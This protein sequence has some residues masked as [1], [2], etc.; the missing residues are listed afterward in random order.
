M[1]INLL[2]I[3][4]DF[5]YKN[6]LY[7][8]SFNFR[9]RKKS[10]ETDSFSRSQKPLSEIDKKILEHFKNPNNGYGSRGQFCKE[11]NIPKYKYNYVIQEN[12]PYEEIEKIRQQKVRPLTELELKILEHFRNPNNGSR[13]VMQFCK[14][15]NVKPKKYYDIVEKNIPY[16][17]RE[18]IKRQKREIEKANKP[19][20]ELDKKILEHFKN[21]SNG[22]GS[23]VQFC[24]ENN[25]L[26][27]KYTMVIQANISKEEI[28]ILKQ[29][30]KSFGISITPV[31]VTSLKEAQNPKNG[32]TF[33]TNDTSDDE[34]E[35]IYISSLERVNN[36]SI[37]VKEEI[38][39]KLA[40]PDVSQGDVEEKIQFL[41]RLKQEVVDKRINYQE[42]TREYKILKSLISYIDIKIKNTSQKINRF[43]KKLGSTSLP[44]SKWL[45]ED[46]FK[47][48]L[49][50]HEKLLRESLREECEQSEIDKATAKLKQAF[51]EEC[52]IFIEDY[53]TMRTNNPNEQKYTVYGKFYESTGGRKHGQFGTRKKFLIEFFSDRKHAYKNFTD[54]LILNRKKIIG[55]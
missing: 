18:K 25:I 55:S 33:S 27:Y 16:E 39:N 15:N 34:F 52:V 49:F 48:K 6:K 46:D 31:S 32:N 36:Y 1:Y 50:S 26:P 44:N 19:L 30:K 23:M 54:S 37:Q 41:E 43:N 22:Y 53:D 51:P 42:D 10:N 47:N 38:N 20:S 2:N 9:G 11:N 24:K 14:E 28:K 45:N 13:S 12:I 17:E 40:L 4:N 35:K 7:S 8:F 3:N 29:H 5:S 21:P